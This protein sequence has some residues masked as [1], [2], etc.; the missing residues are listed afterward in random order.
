[1]NSRDGMSVAA[2]GVV[3]IRNGRAAEGPAKICIVSSCGGHLT[4]VRELKPVYERYEHFFVINERIML[5]ADMEG[6]TYFIRHAERD[7]LVLINLWEAWRI[8][9]AERPAVILTTGAGPAVP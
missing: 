3:S 1:M 5:P 7:P 9:R 2:R 4:E 8:L 6:R